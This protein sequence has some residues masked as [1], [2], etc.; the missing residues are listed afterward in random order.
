MDNKKLIPVISMVS[1]GVMVIWGTLANDWSKSWIAV[2]AGGIA[3][4]ALSIINKK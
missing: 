3:I 4:A 1:V 2:M